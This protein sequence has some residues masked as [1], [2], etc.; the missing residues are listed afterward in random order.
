MA[1]QSRI[2]EL[3]AEGMDQTA[4]LAAL[5]ADHRHHRDTDS[6]VLLNM[7]KNSFRVIRKDLATNAWTGPLVTTVNALDMSDP[8]NV[9]LKA[10]VE[11]LLGNESPTVPIRSNTDSDIGQLTTVICQLVG[12]LV[13]ADATNTATSEDV[14][15]AVMAATGGAMFEGVT[16]SDVDRQFMVLDCLTPYETAH[17]TAAGNL[18]NANASLADEHIA[19]LTLAEL[20]ARCDAIT[21]SGNGMP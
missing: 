12:Q 11:Q 2:R 3:R 18:S 9:A 16:Q 6:G 7:L 17:T 15:N 19:G 5:N 21:A 1:L 20:Q 10:G 13:D 4:T 14:K 8:A